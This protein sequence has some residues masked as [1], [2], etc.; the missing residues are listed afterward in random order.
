VSAHETGD[1]AN[2]VSNHDGTTVTR[3]K[4]SARPTNAGFTGSACAVPS[5]W[6]VPNSPGVQ[7][8]V[9]LN[10]G[11][12]N[13]V[14]YGD[15]ISGNKGDT[16]L[17]R[18][19]AKTGYAIPPTADQ[20][21]DFGVL[22]GS[23]ALPPPPPPLPVVIP[24]VVPPAPAPFSAPPV[25]EDLGISKTAL[26]DSVVPGD[27][28]SWS[29]NVT[30]VKGTP[31]SAFTVTD[32]IPDGLTLLTAGADDWT[33]S[34][35]GQ[36]LSCTYSGAPLPVGSSSAFQIDSLV[37]FD[38]AGSEVSNTAVVDPGGV[39]TGNDSSTAVT[40]VVF[41]GGEGT[42]VLTPPAAAP[43]Q[44][45]G[46]AL[47]FTGSYTDRTLPIGVAMLVLGLFLALAGRR[48]RTS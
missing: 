40:P 44:G 2:T 8:S 21:L 13:N 41:T 31:A 11:A 7:Y 10:G 3:G 45:G 20:V 25:D 28:L 24:V 38:F 34:N 22:S 23:C 18:A 6:T 29:V 46:Q 5:F 12:F 9:S 48:R 1:A 30:N 37:G 14:N 4:Q 19:T 33:C 26:E 16:G 47:P 43:T 39:D 42:A 27:V 36:T 35:A 17:L 15:H 32:V